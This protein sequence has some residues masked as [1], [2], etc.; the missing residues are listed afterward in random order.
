MATANENLF[1]ALTRH[2][3]GL[4]RLGGGEFQAILSLLEKSDKEL[5]AMLRERLPR[6]ETFTTE[7]MK[8]LRDDIKVLRKELFSSIKSRTR[9]DFI[10]LAKAEQTFIKNIMDAVMPVSLEYAVVST[11]ALSAI[12][13]TQPFAGGANAAN[14]LADWWSKLEKVDQSRILDAIQLGNAQNETIDQV[15]RRVRKS[16]GMARINAEAI[17]RTATNHVSDASRD[18]FFNENLDIAQAYR[19]NSTLDGRT[20]AICRA[21]DGHFAPVGDKPLTLTPKLHPPTARP[22]AHTGCRSNRTL[23]LDA[24][25]IANIIPDRPFVRDTRTRRM[26][27]LDFRTE[28]KEK[29]GNKWKELSPRERQEL[30]SDLKRQWARDNIG[31]VPATVNYDEW[32]RRQPIAFQD[33]V[34]GKGKAELFRKGAKLDTFVDRQGQELTLKQLKQRHSSL[35]IE[36]KALKTRAKPRVKH[37]EDPPIDYGNLKGDKLN[38]K[39]AVQYDVWKRNSPNITKE[40]HNTLKSYQGQQFE[41]INAQLRG[42][43]TLSKHK[44]FIDDIDAA[45]DNSAALERDIYVYRTAFLDGGTAKEIFGDV[46]PKA[47]L[48]FN[49]KAFVSTSMGKGVWNF[50]INQVSEAG[51]IYNF[52]IRVPEGTRAIVMPAY[53]DEAEILLNRGR[54]FRITGVFKSGTRAVK[55]FT[56][57]VTIDVDVYTLEVELI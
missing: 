17:V 22:P 23:V 33:N 6:G 49:D 21:R 13:R 25:G 56:Q 42:G 19:W 2:Q 10:D 11:D 32:L 9:D 40:Q 16:T 15:V 53:G 7:R 51:A 29:A 30:V 44:G 24:D 38:D 57:D 37:T 48:A 46:I 35:V 34:L 18:L 31:S 1:D 20:S 27:E 52:R 4:R 41:I 45:F 5:E 8:K 3:I 12:V 47:G 28:A 54:S 55:D 26:R 50:G 36:P 14:T 43:G 39:H